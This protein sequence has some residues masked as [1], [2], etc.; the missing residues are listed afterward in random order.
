MRQIIERYVRNVT[1]CKGPFSKETE[2]YWKEA[3]KLCQAL[4]GM[5][6]PDPQI[7]LWY[8]R[9]VDLGIPLSVPIEKA[10]SKKALEKV[11]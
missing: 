10:P 11:A 9:S 1:Q 4:N 5:V 8:A 6:L 7:P 3:D 2:D